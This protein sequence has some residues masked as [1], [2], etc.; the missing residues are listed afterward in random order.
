MHSN[1]PTY[2]N[3]FI[4]RAWNDETDEQK[5]PRWRF[6]LLKAASKERWASTSLEQLFITLT[7]EIYSNALTPCMHAEIIREVEEFLGI[8]ATHTLE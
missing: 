7:K 1:K 5:P 3:S 8:R 4:L 6:V 2:I